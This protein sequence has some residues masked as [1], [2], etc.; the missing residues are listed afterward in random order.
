[1]FFNV[2]KVILSTILVAGLNRKMSKN[3]IQ[4]KYGDREFENDFQ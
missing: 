4:V 2:E 1:M 3:K